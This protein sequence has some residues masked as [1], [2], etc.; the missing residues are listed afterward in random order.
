MEKS[1]RKFKFLLIA[2][3]VCLGAATLGAGLSAG[4]AIATHFFPQA[5]ADTAQTRYVE[6]ITSVRINP[7]VVP[8]DPFETDFVDVISE[9]KDAVVSISIGVLAGIDEDVGAGSG[10]IFYADDDFVFVATNNHVVDGAARINVSL[11]DNEN[12]PALVLGTNRELDLAVLA[13]SKSSLLEKGAPFA[14]LR[15][16]DSD[17]MR[18][19]DTVVAIGNAMG[20]GQTVTKGIV[21]ALDIDIT[22]NEPRS[23]R[24]DLN[25]LQTDAAVN[26]G[27]S[28]G[29]LIN[30]NGEVIGI[31]TAKQMGSGIEGMGYALPSNNVIEMLMEMRAT[32]F[33]RHVFVGIRYIFLGDFEAGL[34]NLPSAGLL[35][36]EVEEDSP[37]EQAGLLVNDFIVSIDDI[38]IGGPYDMQ[39]ALSPG[40][41]AVFGVYRQGERIEV[42]VVVG[43]RV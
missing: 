9:V 8:I 40:E 12:V 23:P 20:E 43:G 35:V 19:G 6:G 29:P 18:I 21:S 39:S 42:P 25:V 13:V 27:N 32:P 5:A 3:A 37:A 38:E 36:Q 33:A 22:I 31:V 2:M 4:F 1:S 16:G 26:R 11:D 10:F 15:F 24:L 30:R 17:L 14:V 34:F 7:L 28:G 41:E